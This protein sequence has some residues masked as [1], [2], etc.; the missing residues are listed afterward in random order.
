MDGL[1]AVMGDWDSVDH[2]IIII[3]RAVLVFFCV[4]GGA[5]SLLELKIRL[6]HF[7]IG[8]GSRVVGGCCV[9]GGVFLTAASARHRS[10]VFPGVISVCSALASPPPGAVCAHFGQGMVWADIPG[11]WTMG[12]LPTT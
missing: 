1:S 4:R 9:G 3:A 7:R 5:G 2:H 12:M 6:F 10:V 11:W 8:D